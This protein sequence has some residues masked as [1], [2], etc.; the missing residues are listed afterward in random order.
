VS[1]VIDVPEVVRNKA[2]ALGAHDWLE[3]LPQLLASLADDWQLT[4][5][6][7][8]AGGTEAYV[9]AAMCSDGTPA[10]LKLLVP[11]GADVA[12]HESTVLRLA[13][14]NGCAILLR[15]DPSRQALLLERLGPSLFELGLPLDQRLRILTATAQRLWRPAPQ[16]DLPTGAQKG[17]WLAEEITRL[18]HELDQ[19]CSARAVDHA[20]ACADRRV[21]VHD[22]ERAVLVH[23]DV[24][25]WN[26]LQA[27]DGFKLV[28]PDGLLAAAEYDLGILMRE[29]PAE[30][31]TGDPRERARLLAHLTGLDVTAIWEWGVVERVSTG[32]LC[33]QVGLQPW[34]D[35][36]LLAA[37]HVAAQGT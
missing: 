32:L 18:W 22:D 5:G 21:A 17:R 13:A 1:G 23:G 27:G 31:M 16:C 11:R 30:L 37:E 25:Q 4:I 6:A 33:V 29:D 8:F 28:D 19:P 34:G 35:L 3:G 20:L 26:A 36:M 14:G 12:Q 15:D 10:V 2:V 7:P 9:T 24:H